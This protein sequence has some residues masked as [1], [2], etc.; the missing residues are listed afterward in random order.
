MQADPAFTTEWNKLSDELIKEIDE[1]QTNFSISVNLY[2]HVEDYGDSELVY[3]YRERK[4]HVGSYPIDTVDQ[5]FGSEDL[6][7]KKA[8]LCEEEKIFTKPALFK[9]FKA[10]VANLSDGSKKDKEK[11]SAV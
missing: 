5:S 9:R 11:V 6:Y 10:A 8:E 7:L 4:I 3:P 1:M 2:D